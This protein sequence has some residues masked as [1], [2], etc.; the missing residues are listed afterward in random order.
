M[1]VC[2]GALL[3]ADSGFSIYCYISLFHLTNQVCFFLA[4][5]KLF[6]DLIV[7][8]KVLIA[9]YGLPLINRGIQILCRHY[10]VLQ[11]SARGLGVSAQNW[12]QRFSLPRSP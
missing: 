6:I 2:S 4:N 5:L 11:T 8:N 3:L 9:L 7:L 10:R 12:G 1:V